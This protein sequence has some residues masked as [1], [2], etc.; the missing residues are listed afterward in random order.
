MPEPRTGKSSTLAGGW[1]RTPLLPVAA[2]LLAAVLVLVV[3][4]ADGAAIGALAAC[5][6]AAAVG[7]TAV[8]LWQRQLVVTDR[9]TEVLHVVRSLRRDVGQPSAAALERGAPRSLRGAMRA[10]EQR[11][12]TEGADALAA[13]I[14]RLVRGEL[15][16][17]EK[18]RRIDDRLAFE[19]VEAS[20]NL[21]TQLGAGSRLPGLR[22]WA[23]SPDVLLVLVELLRQ[24]RPRLVVELGGGSSTIW[25]GHAIRHLGLD[26]RVLTVEHDAGWVATVQRRLAANELEDIV[27]VRHAPLVEQVVDGDPYR[28]YD[29]AGWQ[30]L[31]D[32]DLLIVDGPPANIGELPRYPAVPLLSDRLSAQ[33]CVL[34]DDA[35]RDAEQQTAARW[36]DQLAGFERLDLPVEKRAVLFWR[37]VAPAL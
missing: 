6:L 34:L 29:A 37:G 36:Q 5:L 27:Q 26:T 32:V 35:I 21:F 10:A 22:G 24:R 11:S 20:L 9:L 30:D 2:A 31:T 23:L 17:A 19:Q 8:L 14:V 16:R 15:D 3:V 12:R 13:Q 18:R 1:R 7:G 33:A 28:W 25:L 4:V